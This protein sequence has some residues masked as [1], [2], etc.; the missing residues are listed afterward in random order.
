MDRWKINEFRK[1]QLNELVKNEKVDSLLFL[2]AGMQGM[3]GWLI[4][5]PLAIG[6]TQSLPPFNRIV[7]YL[8]SR[9]GEVIPLS[10]TRP[11]PTSY[12]LFQTIEE[13]DLTV[14]DTGRVIGMVNPDELLSE[15]RNSIQEKIPDVRFKDVT[16]AVLTLKMVRSAEEAEKIKQAARLYDHVM[17]AVPLLLRPGK[18]ERDI[19]VDL[20]NRFAQCGASNENMEHYISVTIDTD[21]SERQQERSDYY[22]GRQFHYGDKVYICVRGRSDNL[23][24]A[25]LGRVYT[26]GNPSDEMTNDWN[27]AVEAQK[28]AALHAVPGE[29]VQHIKEIVAGFLREHGLEED[30]SQWISGIGY[31]PWEE[32][33]LSDTYEKMPLSEGMTLAIGP[34]IIRQD[35]LFGACMDVFLITKGGAVRLSGTSRGFQQVC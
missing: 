11:H 17:A 10:Q 14:E 5:R 24:A 13:A 19:A 31:G 32:P 35:R 8:F 7:C 6:N 25:A 22:P 20:R 12:A 1:T 27:I 28:L 9:S 16:K 29:T 18:Y 30:T 33:G 23:L 21:S 2:D 34:R 4:G 26:I 3:E 15:A